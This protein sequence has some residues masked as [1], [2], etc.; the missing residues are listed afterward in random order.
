MRTFL[1]GLDGATFTILDDLVARGVMPNLRRLYELGTRSE[2][3]STPIPI[4]PQAWTTMATGQGAGHH[5][6]HDFVRFDPTPNGVFLHINNSHDN[7]CETVWEYAS[8][9]GQSATVLNYIATAPPRPIRGQIIPGFTSGRHL[10][11]S[12]HPPDL[13]ERLRAVDGLD[14]QLLGMD[15]E[16]ERQALQEMQRADWLPWIEHHIRRERVWISVL[17]HLTRHEP[18]DLTAIVFDGVDKIQHLAY[19]YLDP[20][21]RPDRPDE[22]ERQVMAACE[23][24]FRQVDE[25][26]AWGVEEAQRG[27]RLFIASDHGF[28]ASSEIFYVNKW[29]S[30]RGY[31]RWK[32]AVDEDTQGAH[33]S[34]RLGNDANSID[35]AN[36]RAYSLAPST[37]GVVINVAPERYA[38]FREKL[39]AELLAIRAPDGGQVVAKVSRRED[40]LPGPYCPR[41]PDLILTLR[42]HGFVSV[43]NAREFLVRRPGIIGTHHPQGVL[44]GCGPGIRAGQRVAARNILDVAP[45]LAH[46]LALPIPPRLEGKFPRDFYDDA[47]L[48]EHPPIVGEPI[49]GMVS[50]PTAQAARGD[51]LDEEERTVIVER[52]KSLGYLE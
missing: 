49:G 43:L 20:A 36:S 8:R 28:T 32:G 13:F 41:I 24:Y 29:L 16:I 27:A 26:L 50:S 11:R 1:I 47:Y 14:V 44:A 34:E 9:C 12:S 4:T 22:W 7:H 40:C 21:L 48:R 33:Y 19:R 23:R 18:S 46:S 39:S 6:L 5:G 37:N 15:L 52:L 35:A 3:T 10:R 45:L 38:A 31:L 2:L 51:D 30:D 42:D 17:K 25:V